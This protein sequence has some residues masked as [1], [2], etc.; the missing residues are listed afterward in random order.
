M[1]VGLR[2]DAIKFRFRRGDVRGRVGGIEEADE[3]D[4]EGRE[5]GR[6]GWG[7]GGEPE[8]VV[9]VREVKAQEC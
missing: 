1:R 3:R 7:D 4:E 8:A 6:R 9:S 2:V 5:R